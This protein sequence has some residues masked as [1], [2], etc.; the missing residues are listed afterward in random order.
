MY[1]SSKQSCIYTAMLGPIAV[2]GR[3]YL[4]YVLIATRLLAV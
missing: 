2:A 1:T 4:L 3:L